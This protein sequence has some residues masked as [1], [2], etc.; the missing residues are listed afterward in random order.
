MPKDDPPS[1]PYTPYTK[2]QFWAELEQLGED[3]VRIRIITKVYGDASDKRSLAEEWLRHKDRLRIDAS[4]VEQIRIARSAKNAA[5]VAAIGAII[6]ALI[7]I[8]SVVIAYVVL[9]GT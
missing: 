3:A 1:A 6:A 7:A 5:W 8:A 9:Q 2:E 4:N